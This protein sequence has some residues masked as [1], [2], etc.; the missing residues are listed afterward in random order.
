MPARMRRPSATREALGLSPLVKARW[1]HASTDRATLVSYT[2]AFSAPLV[3]GSGNDDGWFS[4]SHVDLGTLSKRAS[5]RLN[6]AFCYR[7]RRS[8]SFSVGSA[9]RCLTAIYIVLHS[10]MHDEPSG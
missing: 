9:R 3:I 5:Q 4:L 6:P 2:S 1:A 10:I 7:A 8:L